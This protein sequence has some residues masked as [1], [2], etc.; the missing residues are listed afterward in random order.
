ME[1]G[2]GCG[3]GSETGASV[4]GK[5]RIKD[6][7]ATKEEVGSLKFSTSKVVEDSEDDKGGAISI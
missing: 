5:E 6:S 2:E 1:D 4:A 7:D 3:D